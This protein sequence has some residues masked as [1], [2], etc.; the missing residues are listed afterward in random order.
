MR[1]ESFQAPGGDGLTL[2]YTEWGDAANP[3]ALVCVHGLT[4]N[5][6]DFDALAAALAPDYRVI[7]ADV[8]GRGGS[9]WLGDPAGYAYPTY[10]AHLRAL[11][12]HLGLA[13][14]DFVGTSMGGLIGMMLA[15]GEDPPVARLVMN[16]IGPHVPRAAL[17]RIGDYVGA[18]PR[19]DDVD[20]LEAYLRSIY[21]G[22]G[23]MTDAQW[24]AFAGHSARAL[25]G[26][27]V[28][29]AYD[30]AIGAAFKDAPT[31]DVDLWPLWDAV[32]C[33][34][35]VL[36]GAESDVL[37]AAT[38]TEMATRGPRARI[39]DFPGV[40]HTP[41]L[42]DAAQITIVRDWLISAPEEP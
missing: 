31:G 5:A 34:V 22:F 39:V 10:I 42:M 17:A 38:A 40:G 12:A 26:G 16:D 4:R 23:P 27:G 35:L 21:P 20:A 19:F 15:A 2:A 33:P 6:R 8:V 37:P 7:C 3:R 24:R 1:A 32:R 41:A 13:R 25:P 9:D 14:V 11:L 36:R 30:P 18:V 28:A 29:L